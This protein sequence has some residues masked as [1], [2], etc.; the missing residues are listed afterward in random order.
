MMEDFMHVEILADTPNNKKGDK[1]HLAADV[2]R[3]LIALGFARE[4]PPAPQAPATVGWGVKFDTFGNPMLVGSCSRGCGFFRFLGKPESAHKNFFQ[5]SGGCG[6][7]VAIPEDILAKYKRAYGE[8][9]PTATGDDTK[10]VNA[11]AIPNAIDRNADAQFE[12]V[13]GRTRR[14]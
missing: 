12:K 2:S 1:I 6:M 14:W 9:T 13:Y 8:A 7:P 3:T 4:V 11:R 5:H 10:L